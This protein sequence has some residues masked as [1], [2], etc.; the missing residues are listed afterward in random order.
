[1]SDRVTIKIRKEYRN[2]AKAES[3]RTE[4][5]MYRLIEQAIE[6]QCIKKL[7]SSEHSA[8]LPNPKSK[9]KSKF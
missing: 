8:G 5:S 9:L 3:E 6:N 7:I 2:M 1:M 4:I